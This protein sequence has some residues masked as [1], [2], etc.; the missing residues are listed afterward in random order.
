MLQIIIRETKAYYAFA[1]RPVLNYMRKNAIPKGQATSAKVVDKS[2][3]NL[4]Y[5]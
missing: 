2:F 5:A 3:M 1:K 4:G